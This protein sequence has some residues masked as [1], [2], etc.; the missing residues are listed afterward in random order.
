MFVIKFKLICQQIQ[1]LKFFYCVVLL[2]LKIC[3]E[4]NRKMVLLPGGF[5]LKQKKG[6]F[7]DRLCTPQYNVIA[8][9]RLCMES[10]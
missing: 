4:G 6:T 10:G 7:G 2:I 9:T 8:R 3:L 1:I 5:I